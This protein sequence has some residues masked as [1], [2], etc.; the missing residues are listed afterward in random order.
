MEIKLIKADEDV[1]ANT[2]T[3]YIWYRQQV[4]GKE[5]FEALSREGF[6][7]DGQWYLYYETQEGTWRSL[8]INNDNVFAWIPTVFEGELRQAFEAFEN[9]QAED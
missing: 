9:G 2:D 5:Y 8:S 1:P 7:E 6:Y 4:K 3:V